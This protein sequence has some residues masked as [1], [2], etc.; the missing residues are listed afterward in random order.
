MTQ[1]ETRA[2][3]LP[4]TRLPI[5]VAGVTA[6]ATLVLLPFS[7][8]QLGPTTSFVPAMLSAVACFDVLSVFFLVGDYLDRG[9]A[10]LLVMG[11]A[12]LWSLLEMVAYALAFPGGVSA[13]PPLATGVSVAPY[14][15]V[16]WHGGFPLLLGIAWA[17]WPMRFREQTLPHRRTPVAVMGS[18]VTSVVALGLVAL[19]VLDINHLPLL[20]VGRD[21][22]RMQ[23]VTGPIVLPLAVLGVA[24]TWRGLRSRTGPERWAFV[25]AAVCLCDL[26]LTY[27]S[28][29]RYSLGWYVGRSLT[30]VSAAV[31]LVAMLGAF[32]RLKSDAE[33][34]AA[35][36]VLTGL[37]NR[38]SGAQAVQQAFARAKRSN[39]PLSV[40][41]V[42]LDRFK[43]INDTLGHK[44]G[45]RVLEAVGSALQGGVR[46]G[47]YCVRWGG[48]E[49]LVLLPDAAAAGG[50]LVAH[51]LR[52]LICGLTI[53]GV[54]QGI[55]ASLGLASLT[56][57]DTDPETLLQ[58][59]DQAMYAA[60][61]SGRNAV[62]VADSRRPGAGGGSAE[63]AGQR[64]TD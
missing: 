11:W 34:F 7:A 43:Q 13:S 42:D 30:V 9:D 51:K 60:K 62:R 47:D 21:L 45:D 14:L 37:A 54:P 41:M 57:S 35:Y 33:F 61:H 1:P 25:A 53:A 10:R 56:P 29:F 32:R 52:E 38:R 19:I 12:Y 27:A 8:H 23:I 63:R 5:I 58:R 26:L 36:D 40:L 49:F 50:E 64:P 20:I 46:R 6:T 48:E 24:L 31:V 44:A 59:A 22:Q 3:S 16:L 28:R 4:R 15:Y 39:A 2:A 18:L 17:P 55:S